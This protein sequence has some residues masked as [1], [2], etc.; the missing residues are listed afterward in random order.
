MLFPDLLYRFLPL[1]F[2]P[3]RAE[4]LERSW[5]D[6]WLDAGAPRTLS[7]AQPFLALRPRQ[8][9]GTA[10][11]PILMVNGASEEAGRRI[12]T[13]TVIPP[14][15]LD[16]YDFHRLTGRDVPISTAIHNGARFPYVSPAGTL[17][18]GPRGDKP[19]QGHIIDGGYFDAVGTEAVRELAG[20]IARGP[21]RRNKDKLRFVFVV[22]EYGGPTEAEAAKTKAKV[23]Y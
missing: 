15:E 11:R 13:S 23:A 6:A 2:L 4:G 16:A 20:A 7:L 21:A 1:P 3:D 9:K 8:D 5:E 12:V 10:W 19:A 18:V 14:P 22:I 17:T